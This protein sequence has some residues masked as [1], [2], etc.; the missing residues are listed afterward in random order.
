VKDVSPEAPGGWAAR[1]S[2]RRR[3]FARL[4]WKEEGGGSVLRG[5]RL[6][7]ATLWKFDAD[8]CFLRASALTYT[9]LLSIVPLLA[10]AFSVLKGLGVRERLEPIVLERLSAGNEEIV[11]R[12]LEYVDRTDMRSLGAVGLVGLLLTAVSVLG[13]VEQSF[14]HIWRVGQ[15]R[16]VVRKLTDYLSMIILGPVLLLAS[17]SM[18]TALQSQNLKDMLQLVDPAIH[19]VLRGVP[20]LT[21]VLAITAAYLIMP[22][23]RVSLGPALLGGLAAGVLWHLSEWAYIRFQFGVA[24]YNAIYGA[25][26]QLPILL[27]WLYACWCIVLAGAELAY[28]AGTPGGSRSLAR[29]EPLWGPRLDVVL[30]ILISVAA[31]FEAGREAATEEELLA[32]TGYEPEAQSRILAHLA[33]VGLIAF[34]REEPARVLPARPPARTSVAELVELLVG[35]L[36]GAEEEFRKGLRRQLS[37]SWADLARGAGT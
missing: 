20:F 22:N 36:P 6:V 19:L 30:P 29:S 14:N 26:A 28:L 18:A 31:R 34:T 25:M 13:N 35:R 2:H 24:R 15:G 5:I 7:G 1:L 37:L 3:D 11:Q 10:L 23:R 9:T 12:I 33:Q 4:V 17:L 32:Q 8:R 27:V 21:T 16:T